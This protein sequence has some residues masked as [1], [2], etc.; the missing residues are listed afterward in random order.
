MIV[1]SMLQNVKC[2]DQRFVGSLWKEDESEGFSI[3]SFR[4]RDKGGVKRGKCWTKVG[5]QAKKVFSRVLF[6]D[7]MENFSENSGG[8]RR[9]F[10][11]LDFCP[12]SQTAFCRTTQG[13]VK[14]RQLKRSRE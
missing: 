12:E 13:K 1:E 10:Q 7:S 4:S 11:K 8:F 6:R 3:I 5:T 2:V 14:S 9:K